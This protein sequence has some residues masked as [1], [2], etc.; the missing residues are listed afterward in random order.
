MSETGLPKTGLALAMMY[1]TAVTLNVHP[2]Q[3]AQ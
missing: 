3:L 2:N 1:E